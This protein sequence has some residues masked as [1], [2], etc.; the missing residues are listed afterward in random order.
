MRVDR[1]EYHPALHLLRVVDFKTSK[2]AKTPQEKHID[3]VSGA[4]I[5]KF[6]TELP[7]LPLMEEEEKSKTVYK[8]WTELQ[9]PLYVLAVAENFKKSGLAIDDIQASY[10]NLPLDQDKSGYQVWEDLSE[11][12]IHSAF[13]WARAITEKLLSTD[14]LDL[15]WCEDFGETTY[16]NDPFTHLA[17]AKVSALFQTQKKGDE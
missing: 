3:K 11:E 14:G 8:R 15:P 13:T 10:F 9:L 17:P 4:K 1:I 2:K 6:M 12:K 7:Y 5:D 16:P